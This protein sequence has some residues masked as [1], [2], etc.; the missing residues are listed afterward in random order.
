MRKHILFPLILL[1]GTISAVYGNDIP[2]S[3]IFFIPVEVSAEHPEDESRGKEL[4]AA[5]ADSLKARG[6][7]ITGQDKPVAE[8]KPEEKDQVKMA[9]SLGRDHNAEYAL[10]AGVSVLEKEKLSALNLYLLSS[11]KR[12][13]EYQTTMAIEEG[14]TDRAVDTIA[15]R[16]YLFIEGKV[17]DYEL[18]VTAADGDN[19][20]HTLVTWEGTGFDN[21]ALYRT[22][23]E[24]IPPIRIGISE[25]KTEF[26][27]ETGRGGL[28]YWYYAVPIVEG[29]DMDPEYGD[30]GYRKAPE[31]EGIDLDREL[32]KK[33][34]SAPRYE[35]GKDRAIVKENLAYLQQFLKHPVELNIIMM[36]AKRYIKKDRI[37]ALNGFTDH[38]I[39][40]HTRET[41]LKN[42][43]MNYV[44][45]FNSGK[46]SR[47]IFEIKEV[48]KMAGPGGSDL[49]DRLVRNAIAFAIP[50]GVKDVV[51][52]EGRL[53]HLPFYE[54]VG[55]TTEYYRDYANW[56][57]MTMLFGTS[58]E[59]LDKILSETRGQ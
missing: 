10:V 37:I 58:N 3:D 39:N 2:P 13:I 28:R 35:S 49:V 20:Q 11:K 42:R 30:A 44:V 50:R 21:Y 8:F 55:V 54:A 52:D 25:G 7:S 18:A 22:P 45:L 46:F 9:G 56:K 4:L 16:I 59:E 15:G 34:K 14:K 24:T 29:V 53:W 36:I 41:L 48:K 57:N 6:Y 33:N 27:D 23:L 26:S 12:R 5:L 17:P 38:E 1:L 40:Y 51:D 19:N 32:N 47:C 31:P 43:D